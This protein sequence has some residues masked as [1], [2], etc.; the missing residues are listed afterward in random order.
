MS[1]EYTWYPQVVWEVD[2][3]DIPDDSEEIESGCREIN[4]AM[5]GWGADEKALTNVIGSKSAK[6]RFLISRKF[7]S[8][9]DIS[10]YDKIKKEL[11]G[12]YARVL[13]LLSLPSDQAEAKMLN[14]ALKGL[15]AREHL[16]YPILCGRSNGDITLLKKAYFKAYDKD[17]VQE[18]NNNLSGD[19][20]K[21]MVM[22]AQGIEEAYDPENTHTEEAAEEDMETYYKAGEGSWGTDENKFFKILCLSPSEHLKAIDVAYTKKYGNTMKK[23]ATKELGGVAEDA[24][25]YLLGI[26]LG[27]AAE[28]I[29]SEIKKITKGLGTDEDGLMNFI[30]RLSVVPDLFRFVMEKHQ[31]LFDKTLEK[32]ISSEVSGDFEAI[33]LKLVETGKTAEYE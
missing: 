6:D 12:D 30:I 33:L 18:L 4:I 22:C 32:R 14:G 8:L 31:D 15:G 11:G 3:G 26:K 1:S 28:T 25:A 9:Y 27:D 7:A 5:K 19:F 21:L 29:A 13:K 20:K 24:A 23:A 2:G 10:L 16:I 17:L